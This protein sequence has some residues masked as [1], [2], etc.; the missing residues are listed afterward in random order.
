MDDLKTFIKTWEETGSIAAILEKGVSLPPADEVQSYLA[1]LPEA[2]REG[3]KQ[4]LATTM[5]ALEEYAAALEKEN[6]LIKA[7]LDQNLK[8]AKACLS[9][10][11]ADF[12]NRK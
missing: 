9:Y 1:G 10:N 5:I 7:Q 12:I 3:I 11:S 6:A 8:N 4:T 2:D